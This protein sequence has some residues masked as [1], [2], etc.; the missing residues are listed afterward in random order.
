MPWG[1]IGVG[2]KDVLVCGAM[3]ERARVCEALGG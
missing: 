3:C 2:E 1:R